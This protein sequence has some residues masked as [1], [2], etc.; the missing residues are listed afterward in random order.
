[1]AINPWLTR[2]AAK[3]TYWLLLLLLVALIGFELARRRARR[4]QRKLG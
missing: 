4:K 1:M 3:G 2:L